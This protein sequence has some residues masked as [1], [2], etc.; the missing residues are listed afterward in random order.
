FN[1]K[2][3]YKI[4]HEKVSTICKEC[5]RKFPNSARL[6]KHIYLTHE[7][8][9][10]HCDHDG[11]DF[12]STCRLEL[13]NHKSAKHLLLKKCEFNGCDVVVPRNNYHVHKKIHQKSRSFQCS[14]PDCGKNLYDAKSLKDHVR[15][16]LNFKRY[17][18]K[19]PDCGYACEQRTNM[20]TH[21]R[22]KH[23]KLPHTKKRQLELN[24]SMDS[25]PN[26]NEYIE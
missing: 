4:E 22:I 21:I 18:C 10:Y 26:P 24:I 5:E 8:G 16:H 13:F 25:Y 11:C 17:R 15:I 2:K 9:D 20:I 7:F 12:S 3:H 19:W 6:R 23:F 1:L 14:W